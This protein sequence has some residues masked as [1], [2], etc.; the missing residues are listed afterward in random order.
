MVNDSSS[1][2]VNISRCI[3]QH[4]LMERAAMDCNG[5]SRHDCNDTCIE[6]LGERS[7]SSST[8]G[9]LS[10]TGARDARDKALNDVPMN[11]VLE[12]R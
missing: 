5:R 7:L 1:Q 3:H 12:T 11:T 10:V 9:V 2:A 4:Y 6:S 8:G